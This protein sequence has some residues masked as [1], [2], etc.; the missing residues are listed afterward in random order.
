MEYTVDLVVAYLIWGP[1]HSPGICLS[2]EFATQI[3]KLRLIPGE[4]NGLLKPH[5]ISPESTITYI[6]CDGD[7]KH[8]ACHFSSVPGTG[9]YPCTV[10]STSNCVLFLLHLFPYSGLLQNMLSNFSASSEIASKEICKNTL[11]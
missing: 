7:G 10:S 2:L 9:D 1:F 6:G 11:R 5:L 3:L 8:H 4:R